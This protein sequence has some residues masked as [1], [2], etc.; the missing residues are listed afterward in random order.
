MTLNVYIGM[1]LI[2]V[3][4]I[5][6]VVWDEIQFRHYDYREKERTGQSD[7]PENKIDINKDDWI[8]DY[9]Y[10]PETKSFKHINKRRW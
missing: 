9:E 8:E 4:I 1:I 7:R 3:V 5:A 2:I 6:K 10:D